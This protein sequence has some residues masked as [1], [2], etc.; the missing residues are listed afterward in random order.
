MKKIWFILL[1]ILLMPTMTYASVSTTQT[2]PSGMQNSSI[3][4][5]N[6]TK[7]LIVNKLNGEVHAV[8]LVTLQDSWSKKFPVIYDMKILTSPLQI[9]VITKEKNKL[10]KITLDE[11][12]K[13][14]A[15]QTYTSQ[16]IQK[17]VEEYQVQIS[18][19]APV[20][21]I[22]EKLAINVNNNVSFFEYPWKSPRSS[23]SI[24]P[25]N[26]EDSLYEGIRTDEIQLNWPFLV[27]KYTGDS[28]MQAQEIY[29]VYNLSNKHSFEVKMDYN[30]NSNFSLDNGILVLSTSSI[31]GFPMGINATTDYTIYAR[32][33]LATGKPTY[34]MKRQFKDSLDGWRTSY[35]NQQLYVADSSENTYELFDKVGS[36]I[37]RSEQDI[38]SLDINFISYQD[39]QFIILSPT[40]NIIHLSPT[41][42]R[43][44][45]QQVPAE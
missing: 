44:G 34:Q 35:H 40:D 37:K 36:L 32:Y 28:L 18:W 38:V 2:Y 20:G 6:E 43:I 31:S 45:I 30:T 41:D 4:N 9:V 26:T 27:V 15:Q 3:T 14:I 39:K 12:G 25:K 8:D 33:N 7:A 19:S 5:L 11:N 21:K 29:H 22:K 10:S 24:V 23:I 13:V 16:G 42:I 1:I 17:L